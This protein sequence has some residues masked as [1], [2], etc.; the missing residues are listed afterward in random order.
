MEQHHFKTVDSTNNAAKRLILSGIDQAV[1]TAD[2][3]T[4]GRG[5]HQRVWVSETGGLYYTLLTPPKSIT[6]KTLPTFT[7]TVGHAVIQSIKAL[8]NIPLELEWPNDLILDGK[9]LGGILVESASQTKT[10]APHH[11]IIGVG[12][13]INQ[14]AFPEPIQKTAISLFQSTGI[15]YTIPSF[16]SQITKELLNVC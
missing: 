15:L 11:L 8:S 5:Q 2:V 1:I 12:I 13:N 6:F 3:Q 10:I 16:A 9:K 14:S 7:T 4:Q